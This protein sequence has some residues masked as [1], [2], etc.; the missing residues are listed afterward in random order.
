VLPTVRQIYATLTSCP[1]RRVDASTPRHALAS[2]GGD[3]LG[4]QAEVE[5]AR[6][7][8]FL[9]LRARKAVVVAG[10]VRDGP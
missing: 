5:S 3:L 4:V 6:S 10:Q 8:Y 2:S 9:P 1:R 7:M